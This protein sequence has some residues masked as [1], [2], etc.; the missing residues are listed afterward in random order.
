MSAEHALHADVLSRTAELPEVTAANSVGF[1]RHK[2]SRRRRW[3]QACVD[4]MVIIWAMIGIIVAISAG[5][6]VL[7]IVYTAV[8]GEVG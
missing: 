4:W 1:W 5:T 7:W 2:A 3:R 6:L 8:K